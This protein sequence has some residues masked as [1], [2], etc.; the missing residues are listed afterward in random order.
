MNFVVLVVADVWEG[1]FVI[2]SLEPFDCFEECVG[3][4]MV[5]W[6]F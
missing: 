1:L 5:C 6:E 2:I 3:V 4:G